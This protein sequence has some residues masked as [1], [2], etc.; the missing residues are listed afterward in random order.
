MN[1]VDRV[2]QLFHEKL[3]AAEGPDHPFVKLHTK[4]LA[5]EI[6][7]LR[8]TLLLAEHALRMTVQRAGTSYDWNRDPDFITLVQGEAFAAIEAIHRLTDTEGL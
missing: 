2:N 3:E 6:V 5:A 7:L 8:S 4:K 1:P